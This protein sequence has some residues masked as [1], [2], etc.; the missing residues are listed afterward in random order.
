L[1]E[2]LNAKIDSLAADNAA[3]SKRFNDLKASVAD[4]IKTEVDA[5]R[6]A[7]QS[8]DTLVATLAVKLSKLTEEGLPG[9]AKDLETH[10]DKLDKQVAKLVID[11][12]HIK[13]TSPIDE[14]HL[15][16]VKTGIEQRIAALESAV[17]SKV[18]TLHSLNGST[19]QPSDS[20]WATISILALNSKIQE[21]NKV[22]QTFLVVDQ[23]RQ[24]QLRSE[25]QLIETVIRTYWNS[26]SHI[27]LPMD[28]KTPAPVPP[29]SN[30]EEG[31]IV[32]DAAPPQSPVFAYESTPTNCNG[33]DLVNASDVTEATAAQ[34]TPIPL[35]DLGS[36][37]D[38]KLKTTK[39]RNAAASDDASKASKR[40]RSRS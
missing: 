31:E 17:S 2:R 34:P 37:T 35:S 3:L 21:L 26:K 28:G 14:L 24:A 9:R 20:S 40:S 10:L 4:G 18:D 11:V 32:I 30:A 33:V 1:L 13:T 15:T 6:L 38:D 25:D 23:H 5:N 16:A 8:Q 12:L 27:E 39:K 7:I 36:S 22:L 29:I 19:T